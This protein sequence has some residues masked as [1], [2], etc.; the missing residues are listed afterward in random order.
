MCKT[1]YVQNQLVGQN[2]KAK[3]SDGLV[4]DWPDPF[5]KEHSNGTRLCVKNSWNECKIIK[6]NAV[7]LNN[8]LA[9]VGKIVDLS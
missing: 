7:I 3:E 2:Q 9:I 6:L 8:Q 1:T 4:S 5:L